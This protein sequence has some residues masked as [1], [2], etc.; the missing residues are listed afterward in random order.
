MS[1]EALSFRRGRKGKGVTS[2]RKGPGAMQNVV[3]LFRND[4]CRWVQI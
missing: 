1:L 2:F 3:R 4:G